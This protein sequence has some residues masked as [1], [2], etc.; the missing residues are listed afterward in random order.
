M[1]CGDL[2]Q[3]GSDGGTVEVD[4]TFIGRLEGTYVPRGGVS[5]KM[6]VLTLVDRNSGRA[7]SVQIA[8]VSIGYILPIVRANIARE[9]HIVTDEHRVYRDL[10]TEFRAHSAV[11]HGAGEYARGFIY[12]NTVEGFFSIFKRGMRGVYQHCRE[13][14]LH[15]YLAEFDFRY[16]NRMNLGCNDAERADRILSGFVGR[17]LTYQQSCARA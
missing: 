4:E 15:R 10:G 12:T 14:H 3:F 6:K 17:R 11:F 9:A 1:R 5:H 2:D 13:K 7:R 8:N 16:S